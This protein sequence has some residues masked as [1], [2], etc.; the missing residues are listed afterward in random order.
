MKRHA[1]SKNTQYTLL[2]IICFF[3]CRCL[4]RL[5]SSLVRS[6]LVHHRVGGFGIPLVPPIPAF[7]LVLFVRSNDNL[8]PIGTCARASQNDATANEAAGTHRKISAPRGT[9]PR[10]IL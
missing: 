3:R 9:P 7:F 10:R 1:T 8:L 4:L 6:K 5:R 2:F